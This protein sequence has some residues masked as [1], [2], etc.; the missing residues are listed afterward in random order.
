MSPKN[1]KIDMALV[2]LMQQN[3]MCRKDCVC[4]YDSVY[5]YT[6]FAVWS[7]M[8]KSVK[9]GRIIQQIVQVRKF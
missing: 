6:V 1:R 4:M 2:K 7:I 3:W 5:I 8:K 9:Y